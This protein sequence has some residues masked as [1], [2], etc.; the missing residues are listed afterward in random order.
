[1][2]KLYY[3]PS[4][5]PAKIA[6]YLEETGLDYE[7]VPID[8]RKGEQHDPEFLKI[9]PNAKTPAM[10]DTDTGATIFDSTA[11]LLY[12]VE[13]T[14][15]YRLPSEPVA[16]G[17][18]LS[19]LMFVATGIG[20]YSGQCVHFRHFAPD[21]NDYALNRY[22]FEAKRH[23]GL[24]DAHL[25]EHPYMSGDQYGLVDIAL[26]GWCGPVPFIMGDDE[27]WSRFPN[28]K[29]L[30]DEINQRPAAERANALKTRHAFKTEVDENARHALFPQNRNL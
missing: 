30:F 21:G 22:D 11:I 7:M 16:H 8:T 27:A 5:N 14:G 25:A 12:L 17:H 13:K 6:L 9:N 18:A 23:W 10:V 19:W 4:P 24:I 1:M 29:R 2:I 28:V 15:Q 26:W 20:P 3:H